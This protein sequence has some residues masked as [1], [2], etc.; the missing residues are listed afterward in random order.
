MNLDYI[1]VSDDEKN[2]HMGDEIVKISLISRV[3]ISSPL[4]KAN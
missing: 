3:Y 1:R 2:V 4:S